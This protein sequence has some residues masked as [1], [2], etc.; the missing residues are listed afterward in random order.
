MKK[1]KTAVVGAG[2]IGAAHI[3]ALRRLGNIEVVALCDKFNSEKKA[4]DLFIDKSYSDY[5]KM[6][7]EIEID[8]IHICTPNNTHF[9]IAKY[10]MDN[11]INVVLEKPM[12]FTV[13]EA[14]ILTELANSKNL[15]NAINFHNRLYPTN[16]HIKN[17]IETNEIGNIIMIN[18][19]YLQDW[20]LYDTDYS[21]RLNSKES[22]LTRTVAD[23]GSHW[24]DLVE[25]LTGLKI[26]EV[27][28]EF[29]TQYTKRK[30]PLGVT[31]SFT[32][33]ASKNFKEI[34]IDTEDIAFVLFKFDNGSIGNVTLS[35]MSAGNKNNLTVNISGTKASINWSLVD[36][37]NIK[38]GYRDK[39]NEIIPK[40]FAI[41]NDAITAIDF[42]SGHTEG[43]PDA[44]KQV[45]KEIY[46]Q[47]KIKHYATFKDGLRQMIL[48]E[49]IYESAQKNTWIQISSN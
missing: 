29:K 1:F 24:M 16:I 35:Q 47:S 20:L 38:V 6:I 39:P 17:M 49:K 9:E 12:T 42:P 10:A 21:W 31:E 46:L 28:A 3:E 14:K 36:L 11:D 25:Y 33:Q 32:T 2:F 23:I 4:K 13:N 48:C 19:E 7:D 30:K 8:F 41:T 34:D 45:F 43:F 40:D 15:I 27:F 5:K 37:E 44:I 26:V 18:G 22:G